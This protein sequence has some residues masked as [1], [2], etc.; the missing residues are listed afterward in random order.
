MI[1]RNVLNLKLLSALPPTYF[2]YQ[3]NGL[4]ASIMTDPSQFSGK[5]MT[6]TINTNREQ[7]EQEAK[8]LSATIKVG[9]VDTISIGCMASNIV[10]YISLVVIL[11]V[12]FV[13]FA[14]A[15]IFGWFLSWKLGNFKEGGS[16]AARMKREAEIENWT[17]NMQAA[18][19]LSKPRIQSTYY[20]NSKRKSLFPQTSR[21]TQPM[22]GS[23]RFDN[24]KGGPT[25]PVWRTPS[26]LV[27][28]FA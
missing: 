25:G 19:P 6:R 16:Y 23:T 1:H 5:D 17:A 14:L 28:P 2:R 8:C 11:G 4:I 24:E 22:H 26:R 3:P 15:V 18:A 27:C 20:G 21:F 10:L 9:S 13:K 7:W 12:I